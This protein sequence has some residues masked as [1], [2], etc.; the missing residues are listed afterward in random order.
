MDWSRGCS[1]SVILYGFLAVLIARGLSS[2]LRWGTFVTVFVLSFIIAISGPIFFLSILKT[3]IS[4]S[5]I[6][7]GK[8]PGNGSCGGC[9]KNR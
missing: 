3:P 2:T 4:F 6:Q 1:A 7:P 5:L 9:D 8:R